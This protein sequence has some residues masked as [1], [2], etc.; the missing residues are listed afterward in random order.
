MID[1]YVPTYK[2]SDNLKISGLLGDD[3]I[4]CVHTSEMDKYRTNF[5]NNK[6]LELPDDTQGNMS[7]VRNFIKDNAKNNEFVMMDDDVKSIIRLQDR[8]QVKLSRD[9]FYDFLK[10]GFNMSYE[11]ETILWGVNLNS[12]PL[13]Y[14][15]FEPFLFTS[16]IL[17]PMSCHIKDG[18]RLRY[19]ESLSLNEDY[20]YFLQVIYRYRKALRFQGYGYQI[21]EFLTTKGGCSEERTFKKEKYQAEIM[22]KK[23]GNKVV[24]Y[25][26]EKNNFNPRVRVPF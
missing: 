17:G 19:D 10:N 15:E 12:D 24:S 25:D 13:S 11:L 26:F 5:K 1:I 2:R 9:Q 3:A 20:D 22:I 21:G 7:K 16:P 8:K 6:I 14:R 23:W 4:L 18:N